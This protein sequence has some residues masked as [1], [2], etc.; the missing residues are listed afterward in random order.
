M[1]N[2]NFLNNINELTRKTETDSQISK[3]NLWLPKGK[4]GQRSG[5]WAGIN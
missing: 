4:Q 5:V 3:I 2:Q 1:W